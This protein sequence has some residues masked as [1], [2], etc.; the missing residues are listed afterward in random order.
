[1]TSSRK[2]YNSVYSG[3]NLDHV[4]MPMGGIGAGMMCLEGTGC[5]SHVSLRHRPDV[6]NEP[7]MYSAISIKGRNGNIARVL[8]GPVRMWKLG[9]PGTA[10]GKR[11]RSYGLPRFA[12]AT[13]TA[14]FPFGTIRLEDPKLPLEVELIGWSPFVPNQA[15]DSS[16]PVAALEYTFHNRSAN[17]IE[18]V[19]S[20]HSI[21]VMEDWRM[22][23]AERPP[24]GVR[25]AEG[26]FV[27]YQQG[28]DA[29]PAAEGHLLAA[30]DAPGVRVNCRWFRG[31]W[32]DA[33]TLVW[34]S[35]AEGS[36]PEADAYAE[37]GA[38][39]GGSLYVPLSIAAGGKTTIRL[40]LCW[41]VP[42][43]EIVEGRDEAA[44]MAAGEC[45]CAGGACAPK[46][47]AAYVPWYAGRF[48]NVEVVSSYFGANYDRLRKAT[49]DFSECFYDTTLPAEVI[50]AVAANLYILK[51]PT[52][53][54]QA[55]GRLWLWEGCHD[56][57]GC[58]HGSCTHVWNYAQ[59]MA[60]LFADMERTLRE[61][62]FGEAQN[63]GGHQ[64]FRANLPIRPGTHEFHAAA[65]GQLGGIIK[66]YRDWRISGDTAWL[67]KLW[68]AASASM[69]YC[70][71][72][73]DPDGEGMLK[74]PHH[75]TYDIE[76]WGPDG[77]CGSFYVV[78]LAAACEMGKAL[79]YAVTRY[80]ELLAKAKAYTETELFDGEYFIQDIRWTDLHA[81][82]PQKAT[83]WNVNYSPEAIELL[84]REGPKYQYGKGC[85]SD[86]VLGAWM[87][88]TGGLAGV[89]DDA[90]VRSHLS[91]V[92]RHNFRSDLSEHANPQR[93]TYA[94]GNE[95]GLLL[96]SWPKGGEL[97]LPF[98][99]SNEVWTGIEYQ[100]ASHL[101]MMGCVPEGLQIV[102]AVRDRYDGRFRNPFDEYECGHWYGRALSSY[103][104]LQAMTGQRYDAITRTLY[105]KPRM[106]GDWKAF[107]AT[108]TG[109]G[110]VGMRGGKPF[111]E[112]RGGTIDVKKIEV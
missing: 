111:I 37:G 28:S 90:K 26:G 22:P 25:R 104:L 70:I 14:H 87:G 5:L 16:L 7:I 98:V 24:R 64:N 35:V 107:L 86:G 108:A 69:D 12:N 91:A 43:S 52:T 8:E 85:L 54:R 6:M 92:Y 100:V 57:N 51:S 9:L 102:Q 78:A 109:Y 112:V 97:T 72:T 65:D 36:M 21:N 84:Q 45:N 105:L 67:R 99:Y 46:K 110:T 29:K 38:S 23:A 30:T 11:E 39:A 89:L 61:T 44:A 27:V 53:M 56:D 103:A 18:A 71:K 101:I 41:Y 59:A 1:M 32:F 75:N 15:D 10:N 80:A 81:P 4:A 106:T 76:F 88:E 17:P 74:E 96:C 47:P 34:K 19:Y 77:M 13:F 83:N 55:D 66:L 82:D 60:H 93:P 73:W 3:M 33:N 63:G 94:M 2:A 48:A 50:E 42:K 95:A 68:P 31:G 79:G 58:C 40:R 62:E 49:S 20:F